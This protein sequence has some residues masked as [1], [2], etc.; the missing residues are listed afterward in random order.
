MVGHAADTVGHIDG[1]HPDIASAAQRLAASTATA[2]LI[3]L[4]W[5]NAVHSP[6]FDC[7]RAGAYF[8]RSRRC[9]AASLV[10]IENPIAD[11]R[12]SSVAISVSKEG[13]H[14]RA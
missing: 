11:V 12:M 5:F 3:V 10:R 2:T 6:A 9:P 7:V 8:F 13:S 4:S 14:V 1:V